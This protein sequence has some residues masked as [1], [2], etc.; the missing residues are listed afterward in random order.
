MRVR[1]QA[2]PTPFVF[3]LLSASAA[4]Q[5]V[6]E[7]TLSPDA[8]CR[9]RIAAGPDGGLW[10]TEFGRGGPSKIGRMTPAPA[11]QRG[12]IGHLDELP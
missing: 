8:C 3:F 6:T 9:G 12:R 5:T 2:L 4:S 7:F 1:L 11:G 10:F